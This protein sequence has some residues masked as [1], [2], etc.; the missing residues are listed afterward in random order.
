M[1]KR[2][3]FI[4]AN[5]RLPDPQREIFGKPMAP[6]LMLN[7]NGFR[8][9]AKGWRLAY[10]GYEM[11]G[12]Q[13]PRGFHLVPCGRGAQRAETRWGLRTLASL[14]GKTEGATGFP[15]LS[16]GGSGSLR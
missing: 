3:S 15:I 10:P 12:F 11:I 4:F 14:R 2:F 5:L 13:T 16:C 8:P 7:P 6:A 9:P 1:K